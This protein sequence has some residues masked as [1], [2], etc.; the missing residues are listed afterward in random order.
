MCEFVIA[1]VLPGKLNTLVKNIIKQTGET[2]P[3]KA[4]ELVNSGR[5]LITKFPSSWVE[6]YDGVITFPVKSDGTTGEE[7]I[8][9]LQSKGF[10]IGKTAKKVLRS[11]DF[12]PTKDVTTEVGIFQSKRFEGSNW[13]RG[14]LN[15]EAE[16]HGF[17]KPNAETAFLIIEALSGMGFRDLEMTE[18]YIMYEFNIGMGNFSSPSFL[19]MY[20]DHDRCWKISYGDFFAPCIDSNFVEG[21]AYV[22]F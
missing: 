18:F 12:I 7:W 20:R 11:K 5:W 22:V 9:R 15:T 4:V 6:K 8:T 3:N 19:M 2:D 16:K 17:K 1:E 14:N 10:R 13:S 21:V